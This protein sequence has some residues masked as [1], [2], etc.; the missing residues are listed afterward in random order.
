MML[1]YD[2]DDEDNDEI[3]NTKMKSYTTC[4]VKCCNKLINLSFHVTYE[5]KFNDNYHKNTA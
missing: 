5:L 1:T 3:V 4:E 2:N